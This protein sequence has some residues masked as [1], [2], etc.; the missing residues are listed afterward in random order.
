MT[1]DPTS[2][3]VPPEL[4]QLEL[5][6][7][8]WTPRSPW[9]PSRTKDLH[10]NISA[11]VSGSFLP[12]KHPRHCPPSRELR[13]AYYQLSS[14]HARVVKTCFQLRRPTADLSLN[15][16]KRELSMPRVE[17]ESKLGRNR[18]NSDYC[19]MI[20]ESRNLKV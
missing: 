6:Y 5:V 13:G 10:R 9:L 20:L 12:V 8:D 2:T 15:Q 4:R 14:F 19:K 11:R 1:K 18:S 7:L 3:P 17:S 16:D